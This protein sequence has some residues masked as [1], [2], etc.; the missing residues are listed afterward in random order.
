MRNFRTLQQIL[1]PKINCKILITDMSRE[2][3]KTKIQNSTT[4]I[5]TTLQ[6]KKVNIEYYAVK[7]LIFIF[8]SSLQHKCVR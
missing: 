8:I 3:L 6:F 4:K 2:I 1:K 7:I 5:K